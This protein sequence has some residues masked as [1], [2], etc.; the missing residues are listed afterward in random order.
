MNIPLY[1]RENSAIAR[2]AR[3]VSVNLPMADRRS[4]TITLTR[5][6]EPDWL[7]DEALDSLAGQRDAIGEVV[8]LD[9]L[10]QEDYAK[11]VEERSTAALTFRCVPCEPNGLSYARNR[12]LELADNDI[13]LFIDPDAVADV[14][15]AAGLTAA[16]NEPGVAIAGSRILPRWRGTPPILARSKVVLDQYSLLDW[17]EETIPANRVVGAGFGLN[18]RRVG[19]NGY[20]DTE[21]GRRDGKLFGGEESELCSR[22]TASGG[23]IVYTGEALV[24]HQILPERLR[25]SWVYRRLYYAGIDR[26][27]QGG[28]PDPSKRPGLAD[29]LLLPL[30]LPP[31]LAGYLRL[32]LNAAGF[33][34]ST[35]RP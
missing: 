16:L 7:V 12:G 25:W 10:W 28:M 3:S 30:I 11:A 24:H 4:A 1:R 22:V 17:G 29:W 20:F 31:Y 14:D 27:R 18:K 8:F 33:R 32:R 5:Y 6:R 26:G 15:W 19:R 9:Q 23:Q 35:A 34:R 2:T 21:F 13:V